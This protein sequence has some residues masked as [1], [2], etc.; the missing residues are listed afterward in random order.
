MPRVC[1]ICTHPN[2]AD[3]DAALI[4]GDPT[5]RIA[6]QYGASDTSL[7]RHKEHIPV[8][9]A[10][11]VEAE[12]IRMADNLLDQLRDLQ[13]RTLKILCKAESSNDLRVAVSAIS[14]VRS[15]IELLAKLLGE[16]DSKPTIN[17]LISPEWIRV[18]TVLM[19]ALIPFPEAR[20]TV[21]E[22]LESLSTNEYR[23]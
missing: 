22:S 7:R 15:N 3:I 4:S 11:A 8:A 19:D 14:Q 16:L 20:M 21:A 10:Q 5:R 17:V 23:H 12:E 18:R 1:T 2:R 13:Q 6:A 9:L